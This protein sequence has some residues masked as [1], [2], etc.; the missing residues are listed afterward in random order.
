[1]TLLLVSFL[2]RAGGGGG[3]WLM[4]LGLGLLFRRENYLLSIM[5]KFKPPSP[6]APVSVEDH[7][8]LISDPEERRGMTPMDV[9]VLRFSRNPKTEEEWNQCHFYDSSET[10]PSCCRLGLFFWVEDFA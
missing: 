7:W 9:Q 5:R 10:L 3:G 2:V 4:V 8:G 6:L 1:M